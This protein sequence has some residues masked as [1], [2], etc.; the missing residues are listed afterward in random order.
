M[1]NNY[2]FDN[3]YYK[4]MPETTN[5]LF[6]L[7]SPKQLQ[8]LYT[9]HIARGVIADDEEFPW[10]VRKA[11]RYDLDWCNDQMDDDVIW[12]NSRLGAKYQ[13]KGDG[14][15]LMYH[16]NYIKRAGNI[17]GYGAQRTGDCVSWAI[18][19]VLELLRIQNIHQ[20][21]WEE[22]YKRQATAG[23]YSGRGHTGQGASPTRLS[24]YACKIGTLF[25]ESYLNGKYDFTN[26]S[27]YVRW[28]MQNGRRGMPDD[29]LELTKSYHA[30]EY[31]VITTPEGLRDAWAAGE[32][33]GGCQIHCGSGIGVD[34]RGDPVSRL[35]G[36]WSHDMGL[37]GYDDTKEFYDECVFAWDQ[38]WGNWNRLTN[39]PTPWQPLTQGM[40]FLAESSMPR[41]LRSRGTCAFFG[42]EGKPA[43]PSNVIW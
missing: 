3:P 8:K 24:A 39:V 14:K 9:N 38:S 13:G 5:D 43:Q 36:S 4:L 11:A 15:R 26:Y 16:Q 23:I 10:Y 33:E 19:F 28:G 17:A 21:K 25:E 7:P 27:Q 18:R 6:S 12:E 35:R 30:I 40:F 22:W 42:F 34:D 1:L 29:L 32:E 41:A 37:S 31:R 2:L 20:G